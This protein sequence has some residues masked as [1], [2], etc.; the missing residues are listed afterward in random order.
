MPTCPVP[1]ANNVG[2]DI[3]LRTTLAVPSVYS[4]PK[5]SPLA[6]PISP[7]T[8]SETA[9]SDPPAIRNALNVPPQRQASAIATKPSASSD[10]SFT[11][12]DSVISTMP[13]KRFAI[14]SH[15]AQSSLPCGQAQGFGRSG[16]AA[17]TPRSANSVP[18]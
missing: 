16:L 2:N 17:S 6:Q 10:G 13:S 12:E 18:A 1:S 11:C 4:Q 14:G 7:I 8:A 9:V 15:R 3:Q 5:P